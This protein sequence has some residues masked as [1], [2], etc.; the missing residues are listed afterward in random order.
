M[1]PPPGYPD[2]QNQVCLLHRAL[3]GLK[4]APRAWFAKFNSV[5]AQQGFTPSSYDSA[6]FIRY[7]STDITLILLYVDVPYINYYAMYTEKC[8]K[9]CKVGLQ[10]SSKYRDK[11]NQNT[12]LNKYL[13]V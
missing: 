4:Q 9:A 5:V 7:T 2:S 6:L 10:R 11:T 13:K 1:Q 12:D 3:Y 8:F